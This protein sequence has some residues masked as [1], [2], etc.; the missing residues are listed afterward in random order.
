M[1]QS[2]ELTEKFL[3]T[4]STQIVPHWQSLLYPTAWY[5]IT[6]IKIYNV[7]YCTGKDTGP[8]DVLAIH[9][10]PQTN[11]TKLAT[12]TDDTAFQFSH[13][14]KSSIGVRT[15]LYNTRSWLKKRQM[16][17]NKKRT[18]DI[19]NT[20]SKKKKT[21]IITTYR[22]RVISWYPSYSEDEVESS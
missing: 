16:K 5:A 9:S 1:L 13:W 4:Y 19:H 8:I 14:M 21:Q 17:T 7:R 22:A 6:K 10:L 3:Q 15:V 18:S 12:F 2:Q 20:P 11:Q